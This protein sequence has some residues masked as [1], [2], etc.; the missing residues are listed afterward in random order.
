MT[1][2]METGDSTRYAL[3][4][5]A[6]M[7]VVSGC[8]ETAAPP[9][10]G[11]DVAHGAA[12]EA[13]VTKGPH[14]GRL[15]TDDGFTLELAIFETGV[16][17]EF[18]AW[19]SLDGRT[20]DPREVELEVTLTR[21]GERQDHIEFEA[22][23]DYLRGDQEIYEPHSFAVA[24]ATTYR[25]TPHRWQYDS[26]EGR[27]R[28]EADVAGA[29]GLATEVAGPA[30]LR[31]S[32]TVYGRVVADPERVATV[33]ARFDGTIRSMTASVGDAVRQG[34]ELAAVESDRS[35]ETYTVV[36]PISGTVTERLA[37]PGEQTKGRALLTIMDTSTVWAEL[38][39]FPVD[40][41]RVAVGQ[42]VELWPALGQRRQVGSIARFTTTSARNQAATAIVPL[43]NADAVFQPGIYL[44]AEIQ[45]AE[46]TVPLA[47]NRSGLQ[48]FRDFTVVY[49]QVGEQYEVRMLE[50]GRQDDTWVEV[51]GGLE[52]GTHYVTENSYLVK[53]DIEKSGASHDH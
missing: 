20:I 17:P 49:A 8:S 5:A 27:T 3:L 1:V 43:S 28:I 25:G 4:L 39:I 15:L 2:M 10:D 37:N 42:R 51:L 38:A 52:A 36:A 48:S 47:V 26:F 30:T 16:P 24:V 6:L 32:I 35:L 41:S 31:E 21:L 7:A 14:G 11:A 13:E 44:Q 22:H 29:F 34:Q 12:V 18:R 19:P 40:R 33:S 46:H 50:L 23:E 53:A 9:L 45:V